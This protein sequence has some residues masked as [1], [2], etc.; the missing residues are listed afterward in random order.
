MS[1]PFGIT[2]QPFVIIYSLAIKYYNTFDVTKPTN[3]K[4]K[5][6]V[7]VFVYVVKLVVTTITLLLF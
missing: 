3:L 6:M 1:L 5:I 2:K 7:T 4:N